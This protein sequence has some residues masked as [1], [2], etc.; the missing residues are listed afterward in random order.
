[1]VKNVILHMGHHGSIPLPSL[2]NHSDLSLLVS[3][4]K[5]GRYEA[6]SNALNL[7]LNKWGYQTTPRVP[8]GHMHQFWNLSAPPSS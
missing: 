6:L 4:K 8:L 7:V 5:N 1:M 2:K 3:K